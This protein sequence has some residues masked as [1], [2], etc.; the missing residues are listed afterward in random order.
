MK[1]QM[2]GFPYQ[3][4]SQQNS[5]LYL[6]CVSAP[7]KNQSVQRALDEKNGVKKQTLRVL[8]L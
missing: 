1:R 4:S 7:V 5:L 8:E 6:M 2:A 3:F